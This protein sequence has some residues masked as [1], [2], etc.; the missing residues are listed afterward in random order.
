MKFLI[1]LLLILAIAASGFLLWSC[2]F[3][4]GYYSAMTKVN[5]QNKDA[6]KKLKEIERMIKEELCPNI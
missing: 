6:V 2:G 5:T 4:S 3:K 1:E